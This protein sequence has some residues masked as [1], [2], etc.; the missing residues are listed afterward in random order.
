MGKGEDETKERIQ[1]I[2]LG[3]SLQNFAR[4]CIR[5]FACV[6]YGE[7]GRGNE[8]KAG[9]G[10]MP[11]FLGCFCLERTEQ[12]LMT[13]T[14]KES[15]KGSRIKAKVEGKGKAVHFLFRHLK[16]EVTVA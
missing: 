10:N 5:M 2:F 8:S 14:E 11:N 4:N 6:R 9:I 16:L 3:Q 7:V 1:K 15:R 13:F 12:M